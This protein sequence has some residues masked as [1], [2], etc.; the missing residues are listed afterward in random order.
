MATLADS[1]LDD[2]DELGESSDEETQEEGGEKTAAGGGKIKD[3]IVE[4]SDGMEVRAVRVVASFGMRADRYLA[5]GVT[6]WGCIH[7]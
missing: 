4:G 6:K 3:E 5:D 7:Q 1:F 2:L